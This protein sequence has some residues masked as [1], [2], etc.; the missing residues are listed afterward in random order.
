MTAPAPDAPAPTAPTSAERVASGVAL[1]ALGLATLHF[2]TR[3]LDGG[4]VFW[5]V[6]AGEEILTTGRVPGV[7][8]WSY[9]AAGATWNNHEWLFEA[10]VAALHRAG[11]WAAIRWLV[12]ALVAVPLALV[13]RAA[14][15]ALGPAW[16]PLAVS[17]AAVLG[18]FK[19]IP[20]PQTAS[21]ALFALGYAAFL[22]GER[23]LEGRRLAAL[24]ALLV[25]W[26][27]VTAEVVTFLPFVLLDA[28]LRAASWGDPARARRHALHLAAVC[29][30]VLV[31]PPA[32][33]VLEY[34]LRGTAVNRAV[35][36]EFRALWEPAGTVPGL[37][38]LL[39][40]AVVL[41]WL[42]RALRAALRDGVSLAWARDEAPAALA[43]LGATLFE[44]NLYLLVLPA[45]S[46]ARGLR[47]A[48]AP[49]PRGPVA[50]ALVAASLALFGAFGAAIGW[51][52]ALAARSLTAPAYWSTSL[53]PGALPEACAGDRA[54]LPPGA[55]V[56]TS[57]LWASYLLWRRPDVRVFIDGRNRE[58]PEVLHRAAADIARGAPIA[59]TLLDATRTERVL[60]PPGWSDLPGLRGSGWAPLGGAR[61]CAVYA[62]APSLRGHP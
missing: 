10:L 42:G 32:S 57:R 28:A 14:W 1:A 61:G 54:T 53:R 8:S 35:N 20:A 41:A 55:R 16:A 33:S 56:Y 36:A 51:S 2:A 26:A 30:A 23:P 17:F 12:A 46:L 44:R 45:A 21:A 49:L 18:S 25:V 3:P 50:A 4:D 11:G 7:E 47:G 27:N 60:A 24:G 6:R 58:Y 5:M 38:K 59:P 40:A 29:M 37:V 13:G 31:T 62:R 52:P 39:G 48:L 34:A 9:T 19:L 22:R 15:R 43:C